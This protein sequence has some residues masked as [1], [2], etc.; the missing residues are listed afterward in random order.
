MQLSCKIK[1]KGEEAIIGRK[2]SVAKPKKTNIPKQSD[3]IQK[4]SRKKAIEKSYQA[5]IEV[6]QNIQK[7]ASC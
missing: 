5:E 3:R 6:R 1:K 4:K 7:W 2:V